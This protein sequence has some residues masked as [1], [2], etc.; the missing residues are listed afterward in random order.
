MDVTLYRSTNKRTTNNRI[1]SVKNDNVD[2]Y[3]SLNI[4]SLDQ[5]VDQLEGKQSLQLST[6]LMAFVFLLRIKFAQQNLFTSS[7]I[8]FVFFSICFDQT[9][10]FSFDM[11]IL[12]SQKGK[13]QLT[14]N[15]YIY[16]LIKMLKTIY[17]KCFRSPECHS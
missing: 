8:L 12:T 5:A 6:R 7:F 15:G 11:E 1:I 2:Y 13:P 16:K 14:I 3:A 4:R 17:W 9:L 10:L